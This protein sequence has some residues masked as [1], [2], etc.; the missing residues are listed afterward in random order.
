LLSLEP[1][2][3]RRI[4][5]WQPHGWPHRVLAVLA[6]VDRLQTLSATLG[7]QPYEQLAVPPACGVI[8]G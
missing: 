6:G 3:R 4:D 5:P 8:R 1:V 2:A 7:Y